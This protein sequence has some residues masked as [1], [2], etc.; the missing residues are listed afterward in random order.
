[1]CPYLPWLPF[2]ISPDFLH[3]IY[4][5]NKVEYLALFLPRWQKLRFKDPHLNKREN[6]FGS[7]LKLYN[8]CHIHSSMLDDS[9]VPPHSSNLSFLEKNIPLVR[10]KIKGNSKKGR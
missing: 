9:P 1:M 3:Y 4:R 6:L 8:I 7:S 2:H 5:Q 10:K